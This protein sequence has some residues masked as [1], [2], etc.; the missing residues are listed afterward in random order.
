MD[1]PR[2]IV[3]LFSANLGS[4]FIGFLGL[5][6]FARELGPEQMGIFFLFQ[7][8]LSI[9]ALPADLGIRE[10]I[11]KRI[12]EDES[13]ANILSTGLL[14]KLCFSLVL[15]IGV[16]VARDHIN[17]YIG[18][19]VALLLALALVLNAL[20][21]VA[22]RTL[23]GELRVGEIAPL[24]L[25]RQVTWVGIGALLVWYGLGYRGIIYSLILGLAVVF[26][27][28]MA[29]RSTKFGRPSG[30]HARSLW[31]Y[32]KYSFVGAVGG[33]F[34]SWLDVAVIGFFLSQ[35]HVGAYEMA[36]RIGVVVVLL[37]NTIAKTIFPQVSEWDA[38]AKQNQIED[39]LPKALASSFFFVGPAFF[40]SIFLSDNILA[41]LFGP[42]YVFAQVVLIMFMGINFVNAITG[43][44][45]RVLRAINHPE[46]VAK[47]RLV[48]VGVNLILNIILVYYFGMV[49]AATATGI[50]ITVY[51]ALVILYLDNYIRIEFPYYE[52]TWYIVASLGM[53]IVI[54]IVQYVIE[55]NT[56]PKLFSIV[57]LGAFVYFLLIVANGSL[58]G[59]LLNNARRVLG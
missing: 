16:L 19:S 7:A 5:T 44:V 38:Q 34:Y 29:K 57:V 11:E 17:N 56:L 20:A 55:I 48:S 9:L 47:A 54:A 15:A 41:L 27:W 49:G 24:Q 3:K 21:S 22:R 40:G 43:I 28:G 51:T 31:T 45:A 4:H 36:W 32:S 37:S 33:S 8:V 23:K 46:L 12:S 6:L 42:G 13:P 10:G 26:V 18:G 52:V 14:L 58:R 1:I 59:K 39:L 30:E 25:A 53:V 50:A 35:T 2:S